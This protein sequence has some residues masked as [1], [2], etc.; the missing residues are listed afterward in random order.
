MT[1]LLLGVMLAALGL[2]INAAA[3]A[4]LTGAWKLD[5]KPDLSGHETSHDCTFK[6]SGQK[7]AIDCEGQKIS[8]EVKGRNVTFE[9][10]TGKQNEFTLRYT[11]TLDENGTTIKGAWHLTSENREGNFEAHKQEQK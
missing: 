7:L 4:D 11:G 9:H 2:S 6:Q 10:K 8:G 1:R 5:F 3:A